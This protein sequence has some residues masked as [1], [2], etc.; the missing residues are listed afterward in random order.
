MKKKLMKYG[1]FMIMLCF[2]SCS[3][4]KK[5]VNALPPETQSGANTFGCLVDGRAWIPTGTNAIGSKPISGG[6]IAALPPI[7]SNATNISLL[8]SRDNE[9]ISFYIRN[10]DRVGTY[11]LNFNT[12]PEPASLYPQNYG[13]FISYYTGGGDFYMT[14]TTYTG[15]VEIT[16]ADSVNRIVSGRFSFTGVSSIGKTIKITDGR[17]DLNS[18]TQ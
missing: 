11:P 10:V 6:Y 18:N 12:Q 4:C 7:Y 5:E 14:T 17:F 9:R 3:S 15:S 2:A 1:I 13:G 8:T 16:R